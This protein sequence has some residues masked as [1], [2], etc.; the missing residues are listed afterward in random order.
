M[1]RRGICGRRRRVEGARRKKSRGFSVDENFVV[2]AQRQG[3]KR[4]SWRKSG[5]GVVGVAERDPSNVAFDADVHA[6]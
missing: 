2:R 3:K 4:K 5:W 6:G 1:Q